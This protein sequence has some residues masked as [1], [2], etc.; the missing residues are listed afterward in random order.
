MKREDM[1]G[2]HS[3]VFQGGTYFNAVALLAKRSFSV[4]KFSNRYHGN[5][6]TH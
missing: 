2:P 1:T 3:F 5:N 4:E 6:S